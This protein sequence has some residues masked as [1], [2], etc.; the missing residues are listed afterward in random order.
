MNADKWEKKYFFPRLALPNGL[1]GWSPQAVKAAH[2]WLDMCANTEIISVK[3]LMNER[4][5][6]FIDYD[7]PAM[8]RARSE[9]FKLN[10]GCDADV[11][12]DASFGLHVTNRGAIHGRMW[13]A[14]EIAVI[15]RRCHE[16]HRAHFASWRVPQNSLAVIRQHMFNMLG[17]GYW[18]PER[19]LAAAY[20]ALTARL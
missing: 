8:L 6:Q 15:T 19:K 14:R 20:M 1:T 9:H 18:S 16:G 12:V 5:P 11:V 4:Y 17:A 7:L 10:T 2:I 13:Y 3:R